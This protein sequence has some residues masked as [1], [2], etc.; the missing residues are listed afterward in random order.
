MEEITQQE[1]YNEK[2]IA[3]LSEL[4][5]LSSQCLKNNLKAIRVKRI[6]DYINTSY[7]EIQKDFEKR[8]P[9]TYGING[10]KNH[11]DILNEILNTILHRTTNEKFFLELNEN[12]VEYGSMF[13]DSMLK[14]ANGEKDLNNTKIDLFLIAHEINPVNFKKLSQSGLMSLCEMSENGINVSEYSNSGNLKLNL[15]N[16]VAKGK[17][18]QKE[19]ELFKKERIISAIE[20]TLD[21]CI[22]QELE[23]NEKF[24]LL[25]EQTD[26]YGVAIYTNKNISS[27]IAI[28]NEYGD[29]V[30]GSLNIILINI[31]KNVENKNEEVA[32]NANTIDNIISR[33]NEMSNEAQSSQPD[34]ATALRMALGLGNP[35]DGNSNNNN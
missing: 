1:L 24:S 28:V 23:Y 3:L 6:N 27:P 26:E 25:F 29:F 10:F 33:Y 18:K 14:Y 21:G 20:E 16:D 31:Y 8:F 30:K 34:L 4:E 9:S 15:M 11:V 17:Y 22:M 35:T 5:L 12:R 2:N 7:P 13:I 32:K 19:D